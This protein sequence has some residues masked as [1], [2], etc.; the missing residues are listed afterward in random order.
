MQVRGVEDKEC[1]IQCVRRISASEQKNLEQRIR[2]LY[3]VQWCAFRFRCSRA[4][5]ILVP[6]RILTVQDS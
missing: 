5:I 4:R 1:S 2:E 6:N 3:R